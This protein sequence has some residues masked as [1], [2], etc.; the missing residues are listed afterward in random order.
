[1]YLQG[2]YTVYN[3]HLLWLII[4]SSG[5]MEL[6]LLPHRTHACIDMK[7]EQYIKT[8]HS[9]KKKNKNWHNEPAENWNL[10]SLK[11]SP[12]R[13]EARNIQRGVVYQI[14]REDC[15]NMHNSNDGNHTIGLAIW[16]PI[17]VY[18]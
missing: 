13:I 11:T 5:P 16:F 9:K 15:N 17:K 8:L 14:V 3:N 4:I 1:M 18:Q 10:S 6:N 7:L 2:M 12:Y